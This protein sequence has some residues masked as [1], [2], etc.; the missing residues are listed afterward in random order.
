MAPREYSAGIKAEMARRLLTV[1]NGR[2]LSS[3]NQAPLT[4]RPRDKTA[5]VCVESE[6]ELRW[7]G[8]RFPS[9]VRL[10]RGLMGG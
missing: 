3:T 1:A 6:R 7:D 2:L 5:C 8:M 10:R 9:R 4:P